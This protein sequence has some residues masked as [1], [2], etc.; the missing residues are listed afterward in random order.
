MILKEMAPDQNAIVRELY[1]RYRKKGFL[2][3]EEVFIYFDS[4]NIPLTLIS[5]ITEKLMTLGVIF[6]TSD[7]YNDDENSNDRT[8]T[9]YSILFKKG[10]SYS[11]DLEFVIRYIKKIR[12]PQFREWNKLIP[13]AQSGNIYAR[14]RLFDMYLRVVFKIALRFY[15][16]SKYELEDLFQVGSMGLLQAIQ[17]YDFSKHGS[18]VSYMPFWISQYIRRTITDL[19]TVIR[20]P[21]HIYESMDKIRSTANALKMQYNRKPTIREISEK[22]KI[23]EESI[24][25]M[26]KYFIPPISFERCLSK[27]YWKEHLYFQVCENLT[28]EYIDDI[29]EL[30]RI[31]DEIL[32]YLSKKEAKVLCLRVGY[33]N[34]NPK[35]LEEVGK[36]LGVTRERIRQIEA[37][38]IKKA[39]TPSNMKKVDGYISK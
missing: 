33:Y 8:R 25:K 36:I 21:V 35:T 6:N 34:N 24:K 14:D 26:I 2:T 4:I 13:Q 11:P 3:E 31:L 9:D 28:P 22:S 37:K 29:N 27:Q 19:S 15:K 23:D 32:N 16:E 38:A 10:L 7:L 18:F 30:R 1:D 12:P 17:K 5:S 20:I 39:N